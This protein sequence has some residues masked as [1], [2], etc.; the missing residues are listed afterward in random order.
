VD[1][2][3]TAVLLAKLAVER[4]AGARLEDCRQAIQVGDGAVQGAARRVLDRG[5]DTPV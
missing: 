4:S 1:A 2:G 3:A 5:A